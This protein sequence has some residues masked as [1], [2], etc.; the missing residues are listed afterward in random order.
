MDN[1]LDMMY[2]TNI[3]PGESSSKNLHYTKFLTPMANQF[4]SFGRKENTIT[5]WDQ[6]V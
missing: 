6:M 3:N 5:I 1:L 4:N 2:F